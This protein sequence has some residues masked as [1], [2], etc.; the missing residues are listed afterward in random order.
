M[1]K[2]KQRRA[3][4]IP[5]G[6]NGAYIDVE[7][8]LMRNRLLESTALETFLIRFP[9]LRLCAH[10]Y[11]KFIEDGE[12]SV[13]NHGHWS[14]EITRVCSGEAEYSIADT[15]ASFRPKSSHYLIIPPKITHGWSMRTSP[16]L[17]HSWQVKIEAEDSDGQRI[18]DNLRESVI[19]AGFMVKATPNQIQAES[20]LWQMSGEASSPQLFGPV[21][22]GFARIVLGDL[23]MRINPWPTGLIESEN[24][25]QAALNSLAERMKVF[26]DENLAHPVTLYDM[27]SHF[28][29]SGRHLNRIFHEIYHRSIGH[30]QR[31]QRIELA[32]RWLATTTR[33]IK[34]IAFSLGYHSP[35]QFCRCFLG[36]AGQT[37]VDYREK[38]ASVNKDKINESIVEPNVY[39]RRK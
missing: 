31:D 29:Y 10:F 36:Q 38:T 14:W 20:L 21:L 33:S 16:L 2:T 37:P 35:S 23:L 25:Y 3:R 18:I 4:I 1:K 11:Y 30:Y 28:N 9:R 27:E 32:K 6:Q 19:A 5:T 34:D 7:T 12:C 8:V 22:S 24:D 17:M 26:L 39:R 15:S 13:G